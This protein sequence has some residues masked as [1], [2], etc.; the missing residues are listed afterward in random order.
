MTLKNKGGKWTL[1]SRK[2]FGQVVF[3][4][5]DVGCLW[6]SFTSPAGELHGNNQVH[7]GCTKASFSSCT[8]R[9]PTSIIWRSSGSLLNMEG[10]HLPR[11]YS[12]HLAPGKPFSTWH[13]LH[14][15]SL[16]SKWLITR[17]HFTLMLKAVWELLAENRKS[18]IPLYKVSDWTKSY[19][20]IYWWLKL[21]LY[22]WTEADVCHFV[23]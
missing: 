19:F 7:L 23:W 12:D 11:L 8:L 13:S 22:R 18:L 5:T 1:W 14:L 9:N 10:I 20:K 15:Y 3:L 17:S 2:A 16:D 4:F 21:L 6:F